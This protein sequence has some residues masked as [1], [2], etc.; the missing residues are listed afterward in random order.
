METPYIFICNPEPE[1][2]I[3]QGQRVTLKFE[4]LANFGGFSMRWYNRTWKREIDPYVLLLSEETT[5]PIPTSG[6]ESILPVYRLETRS[7]SV[8]WFDGYLRLVSKEETIGQLIGA[9]KAAL[10]LPA[11]N[12]LADASPEVRALSAALEAFQIPSDPSIEELSLSLIEI[13][14]REFTRLSSMPSIEKIKD[15]LAV[16]IEG[17]IDVYN[18]RRNPNNESNPEISTTP[19]AIREALNY[20]VI[21]LDFSLLIEEAIGSTVEVGLQRTSEPLTRNILLWCIIQ[22]SS[23]AIEFNLYKEKVNELICG[24]TYF[25]KESLQEVDENSRIVSRLRS[26][27][28]LLTLTDQFLINQTAALLNP[29]VPS[30]N[31]VTGDDY[32]LNGDGITV[33]NLTMQL[34]DKGYKV[35]E[36]EVDDF[37]RRYFVLGTP[38]NSNGNGSTAPATLPYLDNVANRLPSANNDCY[39]VVNTKL[40]APL[41]IEL[42][43]SYWHEEAMLV[44]TL[45]SISMRFQNKKSRGAKSQLERFTIDPLRRLNNVLWGYIQDEGNRLSLTRRAY[46]YDHHY[47]LKLYGKAVPQMDSVDSRSKFLEA[48]HHLL[49]LAGLY[50]K[51]FDDTTVFADAYP[52]RNALREVHLLL[53]EGAHNQYGDLPWTARVEMMVQ[54]WI[55][56]RQEIREFLGGRPM[57]PYEE[58][59]MDRVESMKKIQGWGDVSV[60]HF[61]NLAI[62]GERILLSIRFGD[63]INSDYGSKEAANWADFWRNDIQ[64]YIHAYRAVTGV[65]LMA[66]RVDSQLPSLHLRRRLKEQNGIEIKN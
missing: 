29:A 57:V 23:K 61:R 33:R 20:L 44:Q 32:F 64:G 66:D 34:V 38:I 56:D 26:Y 48:F 62:W 40:A 55:L 17:R 19:E 5:P 54:Q 13:L 50:Y 53:A 37:V 58:G 10:G 22:Q 8:G 11:E 65:D 47:G 16:I 45:N 36:A 39:G 18:E 25:G 52:V 41:F 46:E 49:H 15:E 59:W 60:T 24:R 6:G 42:I 3:F 63:W 51:E 27:Q 28:H 43:W 1:E 9:I 2:K 4:R 30:N 7:L 21:Q 35:D 12:E 14:N 31:G